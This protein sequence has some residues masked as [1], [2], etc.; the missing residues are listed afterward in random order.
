MALTMNQMLV[1]QDDPCHGRQC[2]KSPLRKEAKN[3][4]GSNHHKSW[5]KHQTDVDLRRSV[6]S[7]CEPVC[8]RPPYPISLSFRCQ[9]ERSGHLFLVNLSPSCGLDLT[10]GAAL[11]QD[12]PRS[13]PEAG[14]LDGTNLAFPSPSSGQVWVCARENMAHHLGGV[15]LAASLSSIFFPFS[16]LACSLSLQEISQSLFSV[17]TLG[18]SQSINVLL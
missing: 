18:E 2:L 13:S 16:L 12:R 14:S 15:S 17:W 9:S 10:G 5:Q 6:I 1:T 4:P 3:T 11:P 7:Y 8:S